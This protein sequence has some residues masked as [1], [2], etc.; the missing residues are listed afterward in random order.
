MSSL[1]TLAIAAVT[2]VS[3]VSG[4]S[5]AIVSTGTKSVDITCTGSCEFW[6]L[7][8]D[9]FSAAGGNWV[10]ASYGKIDKN[11]SN[12]NRLTFVNN[13]LGT[14]Y[15]GQSESSDTDFSAPKL[16]NFKDEDGGWSGS[17]EYY[18]AWGGKDPRYVLI[19]NNTA[20]NVFSWSPGKGAGLSGTDGF[21]E[22]SAVP[23]PAAGFLGLF[24]LGSL[25]ALRRR[26]RA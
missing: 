25:A 5:A 9:D 23:L 10:S 21:G 13:I 8:I 4:A 18:L 2:T 11:N 22:I 26:R 12:A 15:A 14:T 1:K 16:A 20:N 24:G 7:S 6:D 17:S 19:K 3:L